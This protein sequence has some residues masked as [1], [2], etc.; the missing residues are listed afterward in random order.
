MPWAAAIGVAGALGGAY[1]SSQGSK[2]AANT[3]AGAARDAKQ[4]ELQMY[5]QTRTDN[6][7][8]MGARNDALARLEA[9]LGVGSNK[10]A[11]GYGS[12]SGPINAG[13]VMQDPG[14]QFGLTQGQNALSR[15]LN[16]RGMRDSG[17]A[18]MAASRYG[19]DY[20]TTKY[21][22][23]FNRATQNRN[24]QLNPLLSLSG[25]GQVGASQIGQAGQNYA[26]EA[27]A[28]SRYA[29]DAA[30]TNSLAQASIWGNT[31]NQLA[32][33]YQNQQRNTGGGGYDSS[34]Y[35]NFQGFPNWG[36]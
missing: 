25:A 19:N 16:A 6:L 12:L 9:L 20:A 14:Y 31:A 29:G 15:S 23:A 4:T 28:N 1:L 24:S 10:G 17:A 33:W 3:E 5:D 30:A 22:D 18:L 26:N 27:G 21:D 2:D 32:G 7:P 35:P 11:S 36:G 8:A 34:G 13:D